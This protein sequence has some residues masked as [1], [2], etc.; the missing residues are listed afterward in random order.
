MSHMPT[1]GGLAVV[2]TPPRYWRLRLWPGITLTIPLWPA[3]TQLQTVT[4][5]DGD[6]VTLGPFLP[7]H[8]SP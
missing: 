5:I 8:T 7:R 4:A 3:R 2:T 1:L 6:R